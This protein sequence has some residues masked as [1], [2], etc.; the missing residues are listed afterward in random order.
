MIDDGSDS[1]NDTQENG[2]RTLSTRMPSR[3]PSAKDVN[4]SE[5]VNMLLMASWPL[6][7]KICLLNFDATVPICTNKNLSDEPI[8]VWRLTNTS[9]SDHVR[10]ISMGIKALGDKELFEETLISPE[11]NSPSYRHQRAV[12]TTAEARKLTKR[13]YVENHATKLLSQK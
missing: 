7:G 1:N 4:P 9:E 3:M 2:S 8:T 5:I 12:G 10:A 11:V 13:G 6:L